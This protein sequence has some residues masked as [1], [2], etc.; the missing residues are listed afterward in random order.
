MTYDR[1]DSVDLEVWKERI[2]ANSGKP[3]RESKVT[4]ELIQQIVESAST[5]GI[6]KK[7]IVSRVKAETGVTSNYPYDVLDKAESKR[8]IVRRKCDQL[9]VAALIVFPV[10]FRKFS[11]PERRRIF[12][13]PVCLI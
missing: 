6:S 10:F 7:D 12:R 5:D 13:L 1:D 11:E 8:A 9:Y 4:I 2:S 3:K